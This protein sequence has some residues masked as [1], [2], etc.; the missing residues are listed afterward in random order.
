MA[1]QSYSGFPY[2]HQVRPL[3]QDRV[4]PSGQAG[5]GPTPTSVHNTA[6]SRMFKIIRSILTLT[7]NGYSIPVQRIYE[8]EKEEL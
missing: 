8:I 3:I 7:I 1:S 2:A 6:A 4:T 5:H